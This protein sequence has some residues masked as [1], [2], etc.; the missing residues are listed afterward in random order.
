VDPLRR[1]SLNAVQR[2][3]R[4]DTAAVRGL[5]LRPVVHQ[6]A[7]IIAATTDNALAA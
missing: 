3:A 2:E 1:I 7:S 4:R 6:R 5:L